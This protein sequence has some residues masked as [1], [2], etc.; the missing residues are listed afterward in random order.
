MSRRL[1]ERAAGVLGARTSRRGFL[2][3]TAV[4]GTALAAA[5]LDFALH[6]RSAYAAVCNCS[7]SACDCGALCC[8]GYTEFCCTLTGQNTCPAGTALGGWWKADGSTLCAGP[9][10]YLD[11]NVLPGANPCSCGC[12]QGNCNNRKSCCTVFRYGQC[13]Q[14]IRAMGAIMCR[15]VT[16]TPPWQLD[17]TC[18]TTPATD[19]NTL[20]HD[21]PCLQAPPNGGRPMALA[22]WYVRRGPSGGAADFSFP[23][24]AP[25]DVPLLGDWNGDGVAT[26]GVKRGNLYLL[27]NSLS[28]GPADFS[29]TFGEPGDWPIVGDWNGDGTDTVGVQRGNQFLL[30]SAN[31]APAVTAQFAF[32]DPGDRPV[33]GRWAAGATFDTVAVVRAGTWYVRLSHTTGA[34]DFSFGFGDPGDVPVAGD[35]DG[36][37]HD[38][39]GVFR[40]G[41]W[42]L[43]NDHRSGTAQSDFGYG[44]PAD[45]PLVGRVAAPSLGDLPVLGPVLGPGTPDGIVVAR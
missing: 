24:G 38:S 15:V 2:A 11:C 17:P 41:R 32:G 26:P 6:P 16:C 34:A 25:G 39:P 8:D 40:A 43:T 44:D 3:R 7:G 30:A 13:H 29:F 45:V 4:A 20:F 37:G 35:W 28:A 19:Q 18:T 42:F 9:R 1:A 14:E 31:A 12:A 22:E 36:L 27:R 10:Y 23:F 5:P 33:A 21:A